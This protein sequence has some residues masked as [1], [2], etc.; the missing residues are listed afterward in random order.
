MKY[1]DY[2]KHHLSDYKLNKLGVSED[3]IWKR[4]NK[5]YHHILPLGHQDLNLLEGYRK[6]YS[7]S[8]RF[9][10]FKLLAGSLFKLFLSPHRRKPDSFAVTVI[11]TRK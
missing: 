10:S 8:S 3:G 4:N 6:E 7:S 11:T 1:Q 5:P 2:M 9:S